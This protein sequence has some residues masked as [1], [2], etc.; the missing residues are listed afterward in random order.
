MSS[1][2]EA[3]STTQV[4]LTR[5]ILTLCFLL[6]IF[7]NICNISI[8]IQKPL[9]LNS[10][11]IYFIAAS[12]INLLI[13]IF[14]IIPT[15]SASYITDPS[16][17]LPWACKLK[18]YGLHSLL[19][20]SR[21]YILMA[22]IDQYTFCSSNVRLRQFS[23]RQVAL[24]L[25]PIILIMWLIIPIHMLV[26]VDVQIPY[27]KCGTSGIYSLIYSIYSFVCSSL[28]LIL[29][30][31]FSSLAF[32]NLRQANRRV[33]PAN[34]NQPQVGNFR[35]KRY[36]YQIMLMLIYQVI[37]YLISNILH[38]TNTLYMA[39]TAV[40]KGSPPKSPLRLTI[41]GFI[42]YLTWGFL[43]YI[44]SCSTF[45][46]N[47]CASKVFRLRFYNLL[48]FIFNWFIH[49]QRGQEQHQIDTLGVSAAFRSTRRQ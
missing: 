19:M 23:R 38:P 34:N 3:L 43:I 2:Q 40:P 15:I 46:I 18:L 47:F 28:P 5:Y 6:G 49:G 45:Y 44:N 31:V 1:I 4:I 48:K 16:L 17:Y 20:M 36:D 9:R 41:E 42:T 10:C 11:S 37:I 22:C 7:G 32:Y 29:M 8:F 13:I 27:I 21:M 35:P 26:F 30:I 12:L 25:L 14:G 39:L 33:V 24:K